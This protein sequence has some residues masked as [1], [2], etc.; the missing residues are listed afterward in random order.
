MGKPS[1]ATHVST[2]D[3]AARLFRKGPGKAAKFLV[4]RSCQT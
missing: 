4:H 1:N 3:P 2:T